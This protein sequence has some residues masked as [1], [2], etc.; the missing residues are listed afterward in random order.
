[1]GIPVVFTVK[2]A[3]T[4]SVVVG[5]PLLVRAI[6]I[7]M[8]TI[9]PEYIRAARTLGAGSIDTLFTVVLPLSGRA[10]LAGMSLMFARSLGEF[11][12][13]IILAGNIP[14]ITQTIP[15]AIYDYTNT[16]GGDSSAMALCGVSILLSFA[17][18]MISEASSRPLKNRKGS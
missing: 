17:V 6:R 11:G 1:M 3:V 16:P 10:I 18:L 14:G 4:A 9:D 2:A 12:A 7:G 13:T 5:F 8:E 15:L